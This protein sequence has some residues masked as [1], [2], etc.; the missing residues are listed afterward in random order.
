MSC[1]YVPSGAM[2]TGL[3]MGT[4]VLRES[5]EGPLLII[6]CISPCPKIYYSVSSLFQRLQIM[7]CFLN[8][9][10]PSLEYAHTYY[11]VLFTTYIILLFI[12]YMLLF[13]KYLLCARHCTKC[14]MLIRNYI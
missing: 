5:I 14:L 7:G 13:I 4:R 2:D 3:L 12:K 9:I 6:A 1:V 8:L 10:Q 11:S